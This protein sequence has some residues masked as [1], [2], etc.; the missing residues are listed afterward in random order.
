[1]IDVYVDFGKCV[2]P[3][4]TEPFPLFSSIFMFMFTFYVCVFDFSPTF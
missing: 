4:A 2:V 1:M 3:L